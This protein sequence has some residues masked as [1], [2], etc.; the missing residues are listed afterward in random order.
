MSAALVLIDLQND[1]INNRSERIREIIRRSAV[2]GGCVGAVARAREARIPVVFVTVV[3]R[4]NGTDAVKNVTDVSLRQAERGVVEPLTC[5]EG[6]EGAALV[7]ELSVEAG[8]FVVVKRRRSAFNGTE[9]DWL[10]RRLSVDTVLLGGVATNWGVESTARD[11]Y[12]LGYD[13]VVL[14]DCCCGFSEADHDWTMKNILP[15]M[16]CVMGSEQAMARVE[17]TRPA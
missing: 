2:V 13:V 6:T 9:L 17:P 1:V 15:N 10:L 11:A 5:V 14:S 16:A 12:D 4:R 3:R 8:D 7:R